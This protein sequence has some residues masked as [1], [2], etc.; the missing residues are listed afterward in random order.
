MTPRDRLAHAIDAV[1]TGPRSGI[2]AQRSRDALRQAA[3]AMGLVRADGRGI[4]QAR[5]ADNLLFPGPRWMT[6]VCYEQRTEARAYPFDGY[7]DAI[8]DFD[9]A[10]G[11]WSEVFF[12]AVIAGPP[13]I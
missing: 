6:V 7:N 3:Q 4:P 5:V 10:A 13:R 1:L 12:C 9:N 11:N 8:R 2:R